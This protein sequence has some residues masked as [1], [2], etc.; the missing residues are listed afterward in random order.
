MSLA[1]NVDYLINEVVTKDTYQALEKFLIE[2][3]FF[4]E[5]HLSALAGVAQWIECWPM[6]QKVLG[7]VPSQVICLGCGPGPSLVEGM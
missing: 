1:K 6:N 2:W 7:S 3:K 5:K 4:I